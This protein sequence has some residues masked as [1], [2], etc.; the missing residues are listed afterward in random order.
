[1]KLIEGS[2]VA[3]FSELKGERYKLEF[4]AMVS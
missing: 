1:M 3:I 4:A 2:S